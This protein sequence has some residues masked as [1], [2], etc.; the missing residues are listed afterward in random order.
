MSTQDIGLLQALAAKMSYLGQRQKVLAQNVANAN[1]PE[2]KPHDLKAVDFGAVLKGILGDQNGAPL[3]PVVTDPKH[4]G[5][6]N[7]IENPKNA[8]QKKTYETKPDGNA[9]VL[10]EQ[11]VKSAQNTMDYN[12]M[13]T[14]YE[15]NIGLIRTAIDSNH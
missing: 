11:M 2:Y 3:Q 14:L 4:M 10:E 8:I 6:P 7:E 13:T 5:G 15:K 9:V 12:L 1:T